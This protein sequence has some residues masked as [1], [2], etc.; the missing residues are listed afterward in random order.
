MEFRRLAPRLALTMPLVVAFVLARIARLDQLAAFAAAGLALL[1][2]GP[3]LPSW[4]ARAG[5][6]AGL[7]A[8]LCALLMAAPGGLAAALQALPLVLEACLALHFAASLRQGR[9]PLIALYTRLDWGYVPPECAGYTRRLT[10]FWTLVLAALA[11]AHGLTFAMPE[12]DPGLAL[13]ANAAVV[14][15]LFLGEHLVRTLRFPQFGIASPLRTL[16]AILLAAGTE[17]GVPRAPVATRHAG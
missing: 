9:E 2:V 7:G 13:A 8:L 17:A 5:F 11:A 6:G 15:A 1:A 14:L 4:R 10:Q 16:R 3:S 12:L